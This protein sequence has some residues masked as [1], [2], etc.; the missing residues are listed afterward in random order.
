MQGNKKKL[1]RQQHDAIS[2]SILE[3]VV[4]PLVETQLA[5]KH[6]NAKCSIQRTQAC[7]LLLKTK[8]QVIFGAV[9]AIIFEVVF[10]SFVA[11]K[12]DTK[13]V[14]IKVATKQQAIFVA[15]SSSIL[16]ADF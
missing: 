15:A 10:R 2:A 3:A 7:V 13:P 8:R 12:L 16:E 14:D 6:V 1:K 5:T 9:S 11:A 4:R